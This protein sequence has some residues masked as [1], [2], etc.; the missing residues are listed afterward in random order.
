[1][2]LGTHH[3]TVGELTRA[4]GSS[5]STVVSGSTDALVIDITH[6]SRAVEAGTMFCCVR[7]VLRDG[8]DF[9]TVA[10]ERGA[11][12]LLVDHRLDGV[13]DVA[14]IVVED[15]RSAI[16]PF[17]SEVFGNP[18]RHLSVVGITGTNGKTTTTHL[19]GSILKVSGVSTDVMG[20]L[21][22][23]LTTPEASDLQRTLA[24]RHA[25]GV[26]SVVME[27]SS[28]ALSLDRVLGTSFA[29]SIFTNLGRDHLDFHGTQEAYFEAKARLF[30]SDLS[31]VGVVNADDPFGRRLIDRS[32]IPMIPFSLA[33]VS[34]TDVSATSHAYTWR[35]VRVNV[36]MGGSVNVMN[37]LAAATAARELGV[38]LDAIVEGL[39]VAPVVAGRFEHVDAGQDF[40]VL[41]DFAHTPDGLGEMLRSVRQATTDGRVIVVFGCGG[42][43]DKM[44]RPIMGETAASLAD[45]VVVTSDN[46][47]SEDPEAIIASV[48]AGVPD[49][50]RHRLIGIEADR[51][52]AMSLAFRHAREGDVV[53]I[54]GKGHERTQTIGG[55]VLEFDDRAVAR[56]LLEG[57]R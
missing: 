28:H 7:G 26:R 35:G 8:H 4:V 19:L 24:A 10:V 45:A 44:K 16:G 43:R 37:S 38:D 42:D 13:G 6:D 47:R 34:D 30:E 51:R 14:Q 20:T 57:R 54:A 49:H 25:A 12:A 29:L 50:L 53:I 48:V 27:V 52:A 56:E 32:T 39:R 5:G 36:A 21:T 23:A 17:A 40:V 18:S 1:M 9:A 22:G 55:E 31:R 11:S 46:P 33:D 2:T 3:R 15:V 41:V